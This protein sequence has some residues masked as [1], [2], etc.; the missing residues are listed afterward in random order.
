MLYNLNFD[1][2]EDKPMSETL[3]HISNLMR[4]G[5]CI[6]G[7][8]PN[9]RCSQVSIEGEY[10]DCGG[11]YN[12]KFDVEDDENVG[13]VLNHINNMMDDGYTEGFDPFW[14]IFNEVE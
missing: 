10:Y 2:E 4:D 5:C 9:W 8:T 14:I 3:N 7:Y 1:I 6:G 13:V 12:I 11:L